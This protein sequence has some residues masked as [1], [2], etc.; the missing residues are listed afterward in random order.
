MV[1]RKPAVRSAH[2]AAYREIDSGRTVLA[3]IVA[4][5]REHENLILVP[6]MLQNMGNHPIDRRIALSALLIMHVATVAETREHQTVL[7]RPEPFLIQTQPRNRANCSWNEQEAKR[8]MSF[9]IHQIFG[10]ERCY[11][12][13]RQIVIAKR[14]MA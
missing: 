5:W 1:F 10:Q 4:A 9:A 14:R 12:N 7:D 8:M 2:Q 3:F 11:S 13:A 6:R